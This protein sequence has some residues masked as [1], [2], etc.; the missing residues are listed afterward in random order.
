MVAEA[1]NI[2]R[3][4]VLACF[5]GEASLKDAKAIFAENRVPNYIMPERAVEALVG[6]GKAARLAGEAGASP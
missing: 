1:A 2:G 3:I 5:M 4:P 6:H